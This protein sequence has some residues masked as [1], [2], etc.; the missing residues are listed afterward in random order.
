MNELLK[1]YIKLVYENK[2]KKSFKEFLKQ[3]EKEKKEEE[4]SK[5]QSQEKNDDLNILRNINDDF[6]FKYM[7]N[8]KR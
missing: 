8:Q 3:I 5:N 4:I 2:E 6:I 7:T 1:E